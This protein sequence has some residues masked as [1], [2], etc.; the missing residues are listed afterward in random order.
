MWSYKLFRIGALILTLNGLAHLLEYFGSK[1][2]KPVNGNE[3]QLNEMLYGYKFNMMGT[4][5]TRGDVF[6]GLS[7]AFTVFMLTLAALGFT[8]PVQKKTAI[9]IAASLAVMLVISV[10]YWFVMP[11][12]FLAAG[13]ACFAGSAYLDKK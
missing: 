11:T 8:L 6:D 4:M 5:R 1:G 2:V 10:A 3:F 12:M 13:L 9:V 7:L